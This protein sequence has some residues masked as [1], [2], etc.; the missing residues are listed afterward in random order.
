MQLIA[1]LNLSLLQFNCC[2]PSLR[3]CNSPQVAILPRD[4]QMIVLSTPT[5]VEHWIALRCIVSI[6]WH[7]LTDSRTYRNIF[8]RCRMIL[9]LHTLPVSHWIWNGQEVTEVVDVAWCGSFILFPGASICIN[10]FGNLLPATKVKQI[11]L[12]IH[13]FC[14]LADP[15]DVLICMAFPHDCFHGLFVMHRHA[16]GPQ[17]YLRCKQILVGEWWWDFFV[18]RLFTFSKLCLAADLICEQWFAHKKL[19][20][21]PCNA[22]HL[23]C[24]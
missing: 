2:P 24:M 19:F 14:H 3:L 6:D 22:V 18:Y 16:T 23:Q 13:A 11:G 7:I 15:S 10:P 12:W 17:I 1:F 4:S 21:V 8:D 5:Q 9:Q 20:K